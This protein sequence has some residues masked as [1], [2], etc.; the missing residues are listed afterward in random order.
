[1]RR[2]GSFLTP[3]LQA[4]ARAIFAAGIDAVSPRTM[5]ENVLRFDKS[6]STLHIGQTQHRIDSNV[7]LIAFGKAVSGMIRSTQEILG[8][9][10]KIAIGSIP[11][12]LQRE[13]TE[14]NKLDLLPIP[15]NNLVLL[16]GA[17]DNLPD[18]DSQN[19]AKRILDVALSSGENDILLT[20]ISGGGSAL[21]SLPPPEIS[22]E[23]KVDTIRIV[24]K[25]GASI[26]QLN[27]IRKELSIVKGGRL[28][29]A[30]YPAKERIRITL[31]YSKT[32]FLLL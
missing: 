32:T 4:D 7:R 16:E 30:A 1:M 26:G 29:E 9:N 12:G 28:A 21:L 15:K 13:L 6:Q 11:F 22:L 18:A 24:A 20:L 17:R 14:K 19:A 10:I 2:S 5:V 25:A 3:L 8:D 23:T 27:R 31:D